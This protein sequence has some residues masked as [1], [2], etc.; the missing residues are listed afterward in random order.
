M[1]IHLNISS[2]DLETLLAHS[3]SIDI[4]EGLLVHIALGQGPGCSGLSANMRVK[5]SLNFAP[6]VRHLPY[7]SCSLVVDAQ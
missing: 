6:E 3:Y 7:P 5:T 2:K 1:F 4:V